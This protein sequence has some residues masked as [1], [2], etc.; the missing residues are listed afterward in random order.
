M[1]II[2]VIKEIIFILVGTSVSGV[3]LFWL[4]K[5]L[6]F[7]NPLYTG[8]ITSFVFLL[9]NLPQFIIKIRE[10]MIEDSF[11]ESLEDCSK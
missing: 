11:V 7:W 3:I 2:G 6:N 9:C 8:L 5:E 4:S 1:N 10:Y